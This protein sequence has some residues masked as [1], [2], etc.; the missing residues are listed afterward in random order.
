MGRGGWSGVAAELDTRA[1]AEANIRLTTRTPAGSDTS[2]GRRTL[3][4][5]GPGGREGLGSRAAESVRGLC[6][7]G[8]LEGGRG[9][10]H[11]FDDS[12]RRRATWAAA[13][14]ARTVR[15]LL[16]KRAPTARP[17]VGHV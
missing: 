17:R 14:A 5:F 9:R 6:D 2:V 10:G 7:G 1:H 8:S 15:A 13:V 12:E 11:A 3:A 16:I 4:T